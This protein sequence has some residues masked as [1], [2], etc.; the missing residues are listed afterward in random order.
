MTTIRPMYRFQSRR[1]A[2]HSIKGM[3]SSSQPLA[4]AAGVEILQQGGNAAVSQII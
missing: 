4:S 1:S 2:V 3:V